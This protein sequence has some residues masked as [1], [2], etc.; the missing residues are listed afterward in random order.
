MIGEL[1]AIPILLV[2]SGL[3]SASET[4]I[5]G[6]SR[7]RIH[8]KAGQIHGRAD[9]AEYLIENREQL[10][11]AILLGNNL[12]NILA[13]VLA[14]A[15]S[16]QLFGEAGI[17]YATIMMTILIVMFSELLPKTLA[18]ISPDSALL[19]L[20]HFARIT[21]LALGG[22]GLA[23]QLAI[24]KLVAP[25]R[26]RAAKE[27]SGEAAREELRGAIDLHHIEGAVIKDDKDMLDSILDLDKV[28]I[29]QV[30][31]H[32][33]QIIMANADLPTHELVEAILSGGHTR[34]P[35]WRGHQENIIGI[36]HTKDVLRAVVD[37]G[38]K[39]DKVEFSRLVRDPWF[40][41]H[42]TSLR[43]QLNAFLQGKSHCALVV[44]EYGDLM[45]FVTLEDILE[46]IV[47]EIED[48]HDVNRD[49]LQKNRDG[50]VIVDGAIPVRALN[51]AL[52]WKLPDDPDAS[53]LAGLVIKQAG[54]I[55]NSGDSFD[56]HGIHVDII[57]RDGQ[58]ITRLKLLKLN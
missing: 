2:F 1:I 22:P 8:Q 11:A 16:I 3:F 20:A 46:E 25:M 56:L 29:A 27:D 58:K 41:L 19:F 35:L 44:D 30:M 40:V 51:R 54:I 12:V 45:G 48:E 24:G 31:V 32:R 38:G 18:L 52:S 23:A 34:I 6:A 13:S 7:A 55:P 10:I 17:A 57:A 33:T 15:I 49:A 39:V 28:D 5:T 50:S 47:G 4:A 36:L 42:K 37:A 26:Q 43:R 21:L 9:I 53:T 14:T